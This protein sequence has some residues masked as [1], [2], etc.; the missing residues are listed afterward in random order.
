MAVLEV[1]LFRAGLQ[2]FLQAVAAVGGRDWRD[3]DAGG[4]GGGVEGGRLGGHGCAVGGG[5]FWFGLVCWVLGVG[6]VAIG[7]VVRREYSKLG[8][9]R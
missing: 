8:V 4:F 9:C 1:L 7:T 6:M 2:V 3:V 5:L